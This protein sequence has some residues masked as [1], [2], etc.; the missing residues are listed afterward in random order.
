M[1]PYLDG[2]TASHTQSH[3]CSSTL[4]LFM[5]VVGIMQEQAKRSTVTRH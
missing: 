3:Q 5:H 2:K 4:G 1:G